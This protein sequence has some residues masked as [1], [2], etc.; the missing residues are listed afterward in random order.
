MYVI[1]GYHHSM[2][3][4][5]HNI[6]KALPMI[7]EF[8]FRDLGPNILLGT[9][10]D[11]YAGWIGQI[12]TKE[13]YEGRISRRTNTV[14]GKSFVEET[15]P[16]ESVEEYFEHFSVLEIDYTFYSPLLDKNGEPT[17]IFHVLKR[18]RQYMKQN[19][20]VVLKVPQLISAQKVLRR[21]KY[22]ENETYLNA[23]IFR[24]QF[25]EPATEML[26]SILNGIIFEQEY[27]RKQDR[28]PVKKMAEELNK[29]F[30]VIPKDS[31]YHIELR[32]EAYLRHP[33]F[34]VLEKQGVG[35]VLSHWTWL[36]PLRKQLAKAGNQ[37]F[38]S[39]KQRVI[40]LM[41]PIGMRYEDA[42]AKAH[43][44]DKIVEAMLHS[45]MVGET[46]NLMEAAVENSIET[47]ILINN[48]SGGNA[49][50]VA[51]RVAEQFFRNIE[52]ADP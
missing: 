42:Y 18:Y 52:Q 29:F 46:A 38:N 16:V 27:Q 48:R 25:Y 51:Q 28:V 24:R 14:G 36:P 44:F 15:L 20:R 10:S 21:A 49:P 40:R 6:S 34:D 32:T 26:G 11:R 3:K 5:V 23:E 4:V 37:V 35:Q 13:R 43:P 19:D 1:E 50:I 33:V 8:Q 22:V 12:H 41:T 31:R 30:E 47:N 2:S 9:A 17:R 45:E 39:G 7:N